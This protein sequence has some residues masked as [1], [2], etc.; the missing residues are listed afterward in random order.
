MDMRPPTDYELNNYN[1]VI[2]TSDV[3]WDPSLLDNE[4]D[5]GTL[6][7]NLSLHR[8]EENFNA[9]LSDNGENGTQRIIAKM[10]TK[11]RYGDIQLSVLSRVDTLSVL[12]R[13][14]ILSE[15]GVPRSHAHAKQQLDADV[16][17]KKKENA[18]NELVKIN[19]YK[20]MFGDEKSTKVPHSGYKFKGNGELEYHLGCDI[21]RD[22][23]KAVI[24]VSVCD[25]I[26]E[27]LLIGKHKLLGKQSS[28][29]RIWMQHI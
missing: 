13:E 9:R 26:S 18:I 16:K 11:H 28:Q 4:M 24:R 2:F 21:G 12:N 1:H 7:N 25:N 5:L 29:L 19:G 15:Y 20:K 17:K 10:L 23:Q 27:K 22:R 14:D 3:A 6:N 8:G